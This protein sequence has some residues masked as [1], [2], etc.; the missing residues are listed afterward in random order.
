MAGKATKVSDNAGLD[1]LVGETNDGLTG[2]RRVDIEMTGLAGGGRR[3]QAEVPA[4]LA[5]PIRQLVALR[6]KRMG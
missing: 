6:D 2:Y 4:D 5:A 3:I 1:V